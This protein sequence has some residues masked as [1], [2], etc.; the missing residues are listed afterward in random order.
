[1]VND[2]VAVFCEVGDYG[3]GK[4]GG[5]AF[6]RSALLVLGDQERSGAT[7]CKPIYTSNCST[8]CYIHPDS[9]SNSCEAFCTELASS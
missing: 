7:P 3:I 9:A 6:V 2:D 4:A 1:M 5:D 8:A